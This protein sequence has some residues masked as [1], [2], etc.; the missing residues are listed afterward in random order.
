MRKRLW[1]VISEWLWVSWLLVA[2]AVAASEQQ[3]FVCTDYHC[4]QGQV[5]T[6]P[7]REWQSVRD[8][9]PGQVTAAQERDNIRQAVALLETTVGAITGTWRD[10]AGNI[11]GAG[12]PGQLDCISESKNTTTYLELLFDDGLLKHHAIEARQVRRP[13]IF[14]V[15][16]SA[17][18]RERRSGQRFAVDAWFLDNGQPPVVQPL[19]EWLSGQRHD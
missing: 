17:V 5:V 2:T 10:L 15:H 3:F 16:W 11:A 9:F 8:L 19:E 12:K 1:A 14:N 4:E 7:A 6:L 13:W 18:I